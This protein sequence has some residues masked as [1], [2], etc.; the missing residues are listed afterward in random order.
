LSLAIIV[1]ICST[2]AAD[3]SALPGRIA[4]ATLLLPLLVPLPLPLEVAAG[5]FATAA[6]ARPELVVCAA[7]ELRGELFEDALKALDDDEL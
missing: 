2:T 1:L 5:P 7:I 3:A 4:T 6:T